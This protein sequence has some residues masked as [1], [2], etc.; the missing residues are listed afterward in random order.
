MLGAGDIYAAG[1]DKPETLRRA[2]RYTGSVEYQPKIAQQ[3]ERAV[4]E[5]EHR[6]RESP[7]RSWQLAELQT[8]S[9]V[10]RFDGSDMMPGAVG[11]GTFWTEVT[12]WVVGGSTD[13]FVNNVEASWPA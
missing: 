7:T 5:Q 9:D 13:D 11:S 8:G 10:F 12:A 4:A 6:H 3:R 1:T 2:D